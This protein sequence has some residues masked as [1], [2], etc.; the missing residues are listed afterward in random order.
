[1]MHVF[2]IKKDYAD[3][4]GQFGKRHFGLFS[5]D[6]TQFKKQDISFK[7]RVKI[8]YGNV[9]LYTVSRR[10]PLKMEGERIEGDRRIKGR[11]R[12]Y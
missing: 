1:M 6:K 11:V 8:T 12:K 7:M 4:E 9:D 10:T 2:K 3:K 5:H